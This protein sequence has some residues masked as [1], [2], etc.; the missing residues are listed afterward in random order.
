MAV[1]VR[2]GV[3]RL[4][5]L[6]LVILAVAGFVWGSRASLTSLNPVRYAGKPI[7]V[8]SKPEHMYYAAGPTRELK[9][10]KELDRVNCQD[11]SSDTCYLFVLPPDVTGPIAIGPAATGAATLVYDLVPPRNLLLVAGGALALFIGLPLCLYTGEVNAWVRILSE[12]GGG[13]S[14]SRVQLALW[15]A[16]AFVSYM[17]TAI[18]AGEY[19]EGVPAQIWQLLLLAGATSTI[20]VGANKP[21]PIDWS[22]LK[23]EAQSVVSQLNALDTGTLSLSPQAESD[24][25]AAFTALEKPTPSQWPQ[26][27]PIV[28]RA[29]QSLRE[30]LVFRGIQIQPQTFIPHGDD[31]PPT[32]SDLDSTTNALKAMQAAYEQTPIHTEL[33]GV[34]VAA[35][36]KLFNQPNLGPQD[37]HG[38]LEA[39]RN[40]VDG[41]IADLTAA[42]KP[43]P[44]DV[45]A[46]VQ[47]LRTEIGLLG[48][49]DPGLS[50]L[51]EN[52]NGEGDFSRVQYLVLTLGAVAIFLIQFLRTARFPSVPPEFLY[53]LGASQATYVGV[54]WAQRLG[55]QPGSSNQA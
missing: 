11:Q 30:L 26:L 43:I 4:W 40:A 38:F 15:F 52:W 25:A 28:E 19:T 17:A 55:A 44:T 37:L 49:S 20:S 48:A 12:R 18:S 3:S 53:A 2:F 24:L 51:V 14:L 1:G 6:A 39:T 54:K 46:S 41:L 9:D 45:S 50:D 42:S 34:R 23:A 5:G 32:Q 13:L 10:A 33:T 16:V 8:A 29:F 47:K 35:V 36:T 22:K 27:Q 31:A 7:A 21:L